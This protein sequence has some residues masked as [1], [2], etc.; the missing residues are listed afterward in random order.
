MG[1]CEREHGT[2]Q[3]LGGEITCVRTEPPLRNARLK[4]NVH[5]KFFVIAFH[6][7]LRSPFQL[8]MT[9]FL[10]RLVCKRGTFQDPH[11]LRMT[12]MCAHL[13]V[14]QNCE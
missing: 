4:R 3:K 11:V 2:W 9:C 5:A 6:V 7:F 1:L 14:K 12:F 13:G 10:K 8:Q